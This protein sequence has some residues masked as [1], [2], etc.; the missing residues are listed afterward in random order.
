MWRATA[1]IHPFF[2]VPFGILPK[3]Q[4]PK[5]QLRGASTPPPL[6]V[7][8]RPT[9]S[10]PPG[11]GDRPRLRSL[12]H[13][14]DTASP[15]AHSRGID[16][17]W[18]TNTRW[19]STGDSREFTTVTGEATCRRIFDR[20]C[21]RTISG[22]WR[23]A[24]AESAEPR[25]R[26]GKQRPLQRRPGGRLRP[27][28]CR[29]R[30]LSRPGPRSDRR[31]KTVPWHCVSRLSEWTQRCRRYGI[32]PTRG[33]PPWPSSSTNR[34]RRNHQMGCRLRSRVPAVPNRQSSQ[35]TSE[36]AAPFSHGGAGRST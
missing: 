3:L 29:R 24:A 12:P 6:A 34:S 32:G 26:Q 18:R 19:R 35:R 20:I 16:R 23:G 33:A 10:P 28:C 15:R 13:R 31:C 25:E 22:L 17:T 7:D 8:P 2:R 30:R 36:T 11:T 1:K 27:R 9:A 21:T 4:P 14:S 5:H